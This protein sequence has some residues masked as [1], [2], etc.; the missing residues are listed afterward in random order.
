MDDFE[1]DEEDNADEDDDNQPEDLHTSSLSFTIEMDAIIEE[2]KKRQE[3]RA[4]GLPDPI[5]DETEIAPKKKF[6]KSSYFS[7]E[8][9]L[10]DD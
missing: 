4:A 8:E 7:D 5:E 6:K 3:R 1:A 10:A 9:E 2:E